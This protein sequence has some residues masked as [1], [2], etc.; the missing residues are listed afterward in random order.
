M[1]IM[2]NWLF[3]LMYILADTTFLGVNS[4]A[5]IFLNSIQ[6]MKMSNS[7]AELCLPYALRI[8]N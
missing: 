7:L 2:N 6:F 8:A 1:L 4:V 3:E 5:N